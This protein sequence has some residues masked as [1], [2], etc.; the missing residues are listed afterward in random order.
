M[1]Q[2]LRRTKAGIPIGFDD[3]ASYLSRFEKHLVRQT[4]AVP[5]EVAL[6]P[7]VAAAQY[8]TLFFLLRARDLSL[9]SVWS[10][11]FL[12][13]LL[14]LLW[15]RREELSGDI[16]TGWITSGSASQESTLIRRRYKPLGRRADD[17]RRVFHAANDVSQ[18]VRAIWPSLALVSCWADGPSFVHANN[19]RQYL[20]GIEIQPKG[21]LATE[22]FVTVPLIARAA[23][24]LAIRSHFFEFQAVDTDGTHD[25]RH[26]LLSDKLREGGRYRVVVT[27]EGGLYR[28]QL[29]D[30]VQ[31]VG[32]KNDVPLLRFTGKTDCL[33]DMVGEKLDAAHVEAVLQAAFT[34]LELTPTFARLRVNAASSPRYI[35]QVAAP[36]L[37]EN[38]SLQHRLC[39]AVEAG[40]EAN[41]GYR[42]ARA[43][44]QLGPLTIEV[45]DQQQADEATAGRVG[46]R[47]VTGQRLGD[48]KP[49]TVYHEG[50]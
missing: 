32:F 6:C 24:A 10:P 18:C 13:E 35:L 45:M 37:S 48:I 47:L 23:A 28:Y 44:G 33:S 2:T 17:L 27:T 31:V 40:L 50:A 4:M 11:T 22:A 49:A 46:Q 26:T 29:H 20:P 38:Q 9:I 15:S 16:A 14:K 42:Y 5:R 30:E 3:D 19:L 41:P 43:L 8:A 36:R 25:N 1:A 39:A 21:L 7:S 34:E 12:M